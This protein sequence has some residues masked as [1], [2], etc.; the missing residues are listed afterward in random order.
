MRRNNQLVPLDPTL[1]P[2]PEDILQQF[3][4][5]GGQ[6]THFS[7]FGQDPLQER[8]DL[9]SLREQ[10]FHTRYPD[11]SCFFSTV[12]NDNFSLFSDGL[13]FF[14]DVSKRLELQL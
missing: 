13:L 12:V 1:V 10:E 4:A 2:E 9:I 5:H 8:E 11:F 7:P 6:I 3:E 14:I